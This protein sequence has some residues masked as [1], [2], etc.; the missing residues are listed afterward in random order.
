MEAQVFKVKIKV[1]SCA[2]KL[3]TELFEFY[4]QIVLNTPDVMVVYE[5][6]REVTI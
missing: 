4:D 3:S 6:S 1:L 2:L 5:D